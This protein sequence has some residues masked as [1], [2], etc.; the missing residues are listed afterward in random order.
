MKEHAKR[1]TGSVILHTIRQSKVLSTG[2]LLTVAGAVIVALLPPLVLEWIVDRLSIGETFAF[3]A[4]VLYFG[5]IALAG[6]LE[7]GREILLTVFGQRITRS[8]RRAL[9][10]KLSRLTADD[11]TKLEPGVISSRFIGD[12]DTVENLFTSGIISMAADLC[13]VV[14]IFVIIGGKN[15]GLAVLLLLLVPVIFG[16]TRF[17]Q[18]RSLKAQLENRKAVAKVMNHV[19]ETIKNIRTI[20]TLEKEAYMEGRYGDYIGESYAAIEKTNF[21]DSVYSPVILILNAVVTAV[22]M[23]LSASGIPVVTTFFGMSVGTAVAVISYISQVFGPLESIGMEIQTIQSAV[24]GIHRIDEFL[25]LPERWNT[26]EMLRLKEHVPCVELK[27][28]C[29]GYVPEHEILHEMSLQVQTGEHLTLAGRT[30]AGKSTL[31]KLLLGQYQPWSGQVLI[32]GQEASLIPDSEKRRLFGYVEQ[33]F[34]A[35]PG[36]VADQIRLFDESIS[37]EMVE[38]A[39]RIAGLHETITKLHEGYQTSYAVE[40]FSQGQRQLLSIA[41]A[42]AARP[43]ILLLD[44]ITANLDA[45]TEQTVLAALQNASINRTVLSISHRLY[46]QTGGKIINII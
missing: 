38:E 15:P 27:N 46:E 2:I 18:K 7:S 1:N 17:V 35:V 20:H 37:L 28:V 22:V 30:G 6:L 13:K 32:Y 16:F 4:A 23:V 33:T 39:A 9:D 29:F 3:L 43:K 10:D 26:D 40:L 31:F 42:I 5:L 45:D 34:H 24:A 44:E 12:V 36:T 14:S 19:P 25:A 21:F 11:L 41:R 8:L